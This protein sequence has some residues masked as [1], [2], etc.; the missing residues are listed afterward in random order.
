MTFQK[1]HI[2]HKYWLGKTRS[3]E[4]RKKIS[5]ARKKNPIRYWL[6]KKRGISPLKGRH[7]HS[8][9]TK[10]KLS[11]DKKRLGIV[12]PSRKGFAPW[13]KGKTGYRVLAWSGKNNRNWKGGI[14]PLTKQIRFCFKYRQWRSDIFT[15]DDFTCVLCG[16]RGIWIEAD[17]YPKMFSEIFHENKIQNLQQALECE[18]FW[19][20]NN[21]RTLCRG[22]HR[23]KK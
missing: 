3:S 2:G 20:I 15:R 17:H 18:E 5:E 1:G 6:G 11:E 4:D 22:C 19:N 9:K 13:N 7:H 14:T 8:E 23:N 16:K 12:P 10:K 21:G